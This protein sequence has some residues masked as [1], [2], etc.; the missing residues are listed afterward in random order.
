[1]VTPEE[2]L[3]A[4][5]RLEPVVKGRRRLSVY[6]APPGRSTFLAL[7]FGIL[8]WGT[9]GP[10]LH[11]TVLPGAFPSLAEKIP[12]EGWIPEPFT[13]LGISLALVGTLGAFIGTRPWPETDEAYRLSHSVLTVLFLLSAGT[14]C[15]AADVSF[16]R[17]SGSEFDLLTPTLVFSATFVT[18]YFANSQTVLWGDLR[19]LHLERQ[20]NAFGR[21][22]SDL[23]RS[24]TKD[25]ASTK[26]SAQGWLSAFFALTCWLAPPA[27]VLSWAIWRQSWAAGTS[28]FI[29]LAL[30]AAILIVVLAIQVFIFQTASTPRSGLMLLRAVTTLGSTYLILLITLL[31]A[32]LGAKMDPFAGTVWISFSIGH[33]VALWIVTLF[34][35]ND[36]K[37]A[38]SILG[39]HHGAVKRNA[40]AR[41]HFKEE[42]ARL[43]RELVAE[44]Q[45]ENSSQLTDAAV[46][47]I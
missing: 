16:G 12:E 11:V 24:F 39:T 1:M 32:L 17:L 19:R 31:A 40:S 27:A 9:L 8:L 28:A 46:S 36:K 45:R 29:A 30:V 14:A 26:R 33:A 35:I 41:R 43:K 3:D 22:H 7:G 44:K 6:P 4:E 37:F 18:V 5:A 34:A 47:Y 10:L 15:I 42:S 25:D 38:M 2:V 13:V 21:M 20:S 23:W